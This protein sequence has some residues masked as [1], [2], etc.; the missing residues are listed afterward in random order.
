MEI[1]VIY[2]YDETGVIS[3]IRSCV[4]A[5][6]QLFTNLE[7][8]ETLRYLKSKKNFVWINLENPTPKELALIRSKLDFHPLTI[9]DVLN[10]HQRP[11]IDT[12]DD[13]IYI[14]VKIPT[15]SD[16]EEDVTQLNIFL[17]Y[18]YM[19]T[20]ALKPLPFV[21]SVFQKASK[22]QN[23]LKRGPDF[24]A[25][26]LLDSAVDSFFPIIEEMDDRVDEIEKEIFDEPDPETLSMLLDLK[27]K[28]L[29]VRRLSW[30][31]RNILGVISRRDIKYT[32]EEN[33]VYFRDVSDHLIRITEMTDTVRDLIASSMEG[34]LSLV[35]NNLNI[36][37]KK[38]ASLAAIITIPTLIASIYGM[39]FNP[40]ISPYN[41][42]EL[43]WVYGYPFA[44]F[45]MVLTTGAALYFFRK[46]EWL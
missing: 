26:L 30:P 29:A 17:S 24:V 25:Y 43:N 32:R 1:S 6:K 34:Y 19:V 28:V 39:N 31:M 27:R 23:V 9:E 14:V 46:F 16:L 8:E 35:S 13:Y 38:L 12:Y 40:A 22:S 5:K 11:K 21:D 4:Y 33:I 10:E 36:I 42:P 2:L 41:M 18:N 3:M 7:F 20:I 44:I 45:L 15:G 37:L